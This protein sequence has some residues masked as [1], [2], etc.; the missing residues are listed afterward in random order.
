M[1]RVVKN[2]ANSRVI[3][4]TTPSP[5]TARDLPP[6]QLDPAIPNQALRLYNALRAAIVDGLLAPG[7]QIPSTWA[8]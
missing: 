5:P 2:R 6:L 8:L 1:A 3:M 7:M 4:P